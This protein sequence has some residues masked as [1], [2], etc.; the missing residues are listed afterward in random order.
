MP[1]ESH[2]FLS[3]R[4]VSSSGDR[5]LPLVY[6]DPDFAIFL[7]LHGTP[8]LHLSDLSQWVHDP[9]R[10]PQSQRAARE[11]RRALSA[12]KAWKAWSESGGALPKPIAAFMEARERLS[13][14][15][16]I[17]AVMGWSVLS[18]AMVAQL[19][20]DAVTPKAGH[21]GVTVSLKHMPE[22]WIP[23][24]GPGGDAIRNAL[25]LLE[26]YHPHC[27]RVFPGVAS[28]TPA[29]RFRAIAEMDLM[30]YRNWQR[31]DAFDAEGLKG[32]SRFTGWPYEA[33][34]VGHKTR[35]KKP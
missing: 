35:T 3:R 27:A 16:P 12:R 11:R 28:S 2:V 5:A 15:Q 13:R 25:T 4:P 23:V 7:A 6:G 8:P 19:K 17:S 33:M 18:G 26:L 1:P 22:R 9:T 29:K 31:R 20:V 10:T 14:D 34:I 24:A 32:L 21:M 30:T